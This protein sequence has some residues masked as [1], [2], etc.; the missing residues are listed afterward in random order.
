MGSRATASHNF[1]SRRSSGLAILAQLFCY[2][3]FSF[4]C[5]H[6]ASRLFYASAFCFSPAQ[7]HSLHYYRGYKYVPSHCRWRRI[8]RVKKKR[9]AQIFPRDVF[10][11]NKTQDTAQEE[12]ARPGTSL[13]SSMRRSLSSL[14]ASSSS[15]SSLTRT[16]T[17]TTTTTYQRLAFATMARL[18]PLAAN[19][20]ANGKP[21]GLPRPAARVAGSRKDV[22][23]DMMQGREWK[24]AR[25]MGNNADRRG[26]GGNQSF[27]CL[28]VH[29]K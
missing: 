24:Q 10:L 12:R 9:A 22:W 1:T 20:T 3:L 8:D 16:T 28:Q 15:S 7:S 6:W 27:P 11:Q 29:C 25:V 18:E 21:S 17:T 13:G 2:L 23:Y 26:G 5:S 19:P 4:V 14:I